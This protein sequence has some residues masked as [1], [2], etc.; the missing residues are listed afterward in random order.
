M[1][2]VD[3]IF[4]AVAAASMMSN[5]YGV[6]GNLLIAFDSLIYG[7]VTNFREFGFAFILTLFLVVLIV[8]FLEY[9]LIVLTAKKYG[10]SR[11]GIAGGVLGGVGGAVSGAF[12]TPVIGAIIGSVIGVFIGATIFEFFKSFNLR[13]AV[14]SGIGAFLGKLGG[15]SIKMCGAIT[16][17]IMIGYKIF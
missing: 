5:L 7:L 11:W 15:L 6:P 3:I 10:A 16:M 8:E 13:M 4:I 2:T 1:T 14:R 9:L 12:F 17:L